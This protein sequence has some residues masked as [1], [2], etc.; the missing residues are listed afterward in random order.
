MTRETGLLKW[1]DPNARRKYYKNLTNTTPVY[2]IHIIP[3]YHR[4]LWNLWNHGQPSVLY[5]PVWRERVHW[6]YFLDLTVKLFSSYRAAF[7]QSS[8]KDIQPGFRGICQ[9]ERTRDPYIKTAFRYLNGDG[10]VTWFVGV[11]NA[12][13]IQS[14]KPPC[15]STFQVTQGNCVFPDSSVISRLQIR[16]TKLSNAMF[17]LLL[18]SFFDIKNDSIPNYMT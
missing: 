9:D 2:S 16:K 5:S 11:T 13:N 10:L 4:F 15:V 3:S 12:C 1:E 14:A 8:G 6:Q 7:L 18:L 17:T